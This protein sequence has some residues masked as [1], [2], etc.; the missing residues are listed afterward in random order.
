M[1]SYAV[2]LTGGIGNIIQTIPFMNW[3]KE[4]GHEVVA[5]YDREAYCEEICEMA[6]PSYHSLSRK[7]PSGFVF[8]GNMLTSDFGKVLVRD[9]SEWAAWF[10]YHGFDI[11][12][13]VST[14]LDFEDARSPSR[15]VLA[16]CCKPNWPMK[17]WPYWQELVDRMPGCTVVGIPGDAPGIKGDF[18]DLRKRTSIRELAG[19]LSDADYV[20]AEE[21]GI[22][23]LACAV[24]TRT[25]VLYGGTNPVKNAQPNNAV[26]IMSSEYFACRPCQGRGWYY[27]NMQREMVLY[28]CNKRNLVKGY[29]RCMAT[30]S[31]FEVMK[32]ISDNGDDCLHGDF[33][34]L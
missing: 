33:R 28:G 10:L 18:I 24:G 4:S 6:A 8:M 25:Y 22:A 5:V 34:R 7:V 13:S 14:P 31:P 9:V 26:Q 3:L 21:G 15:V 30:L 27:E 1:A 20:V 12:D 19:I 2:L 11:P 29:A 32:A 16:P 23:H 17:R